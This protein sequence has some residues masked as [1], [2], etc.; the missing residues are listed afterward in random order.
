MTFSRRLV[1]VALVAV[2]AIASGC[3]WFAPKPPK[4]AKDMLQTGIANLVAQKAGDFLLSVSGNL[5][6]KDADNKPQNMTFDI[7]ANGDSS[8]TGALASD[9]NTKFT[10]NVKVNQD[11]YVVGAELRGNNKSIFAVLNSLTGP[12]KDIPK[13]QIAQFLNKWWKIPLPENFYANLEKSADTAYLVKIQEVYKAALDYLKDIS[14]E[15]VDTIGGLKSYHYSAQVDAGKLKAFLE[16]YFKSNGKA[17]TEQDVKEFNDFFQNS[18][19][20]AEFWVSM[21]SQILNRIKLDV[22]MNNIVGSDGKSAGKG[23]LH[24]DTTGSNYGKTVTVQEPAD[25]QEFDLFGMLGGFGIDP[26]GGAVTAP[27]DATPAPAVKTPAKK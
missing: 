9:F 18:T 11:A 20:N 23:E 16:G 21:D 13:D 8:K 1:S 14:Y 7:S 19:A 4:E 17:M 10:A 25:A 22:K 6:G 24:F 2:L 27:S 5:L 26:T 15:G 12:E 3:A